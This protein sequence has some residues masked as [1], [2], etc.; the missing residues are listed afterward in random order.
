MFDISQITLDNFH[1]Q[2]QENLDDISQL[3]QY[4]KKNSQILYF[5]KL[6]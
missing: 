1:I 3:L 4:R 5:R 2:T 6:K